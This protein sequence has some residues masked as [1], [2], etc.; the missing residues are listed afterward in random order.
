MPWKGVQST[1]L[2][3]YTW[4]GPVDAAGRPDGHGVLTYPAADSWE[5]L[6]GGMAAGREHG[7]W[8]HKW[9]VAWHGTWD[10][11]QY[12]DGAYQSHKVRPAPPR[13]PETGARACGGLVVGGGRV[14]RPPP[15][16]VL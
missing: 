14:P 11:A 2:D 3:G 6:E 16:D 7:T 15:A 5:Y 4:T 10:S 9:K 1:W 12:K 13:P 8:V